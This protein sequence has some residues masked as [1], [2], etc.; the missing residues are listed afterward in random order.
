MVLIADG[1]SPCG[2]LANIS[3]QGA[4]SSSAHYFFSAKA[5]YPYALTVSCNDSI[6]LLV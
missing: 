6:Y 1:T 4:L 5:A 2:T 3:G